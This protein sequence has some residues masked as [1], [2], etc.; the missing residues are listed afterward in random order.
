MSTTTTNA[1]PL[2]IVDDDDDSH[3]FLKRHLQRCGVTHPVE[4]VF[5]GEAAIA[6]FGRCVSGEKQFPAL[7]FLDVKMP[8]TNGI[9]VLKWARDHAVLAQLT[10]TMLSS[11]DD[12]RD[13]KAAMSL[14][15]HTYMTKPPKD[16]ELVELVK[17][18]IRLAAQAGAPK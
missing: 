14:G 16:A 1:R 13:V 7:V 2:L 10:L 18:A 4:S 5:G 6:Y 12:P 3:F 9:E 15:A 17:S 8:G 11:S